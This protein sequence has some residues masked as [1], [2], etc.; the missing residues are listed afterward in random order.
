VADP[1]LEPDLDEVEDATAEQGPPGP[2]PPRP[3][4]QIAQ[5]DTLI[6]RPGYPGVYVRVLRGSPIPRDLAD[7]PRRPLADARKPRRARSRRRSPAAKRS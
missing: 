4:R 2:A 5:E 6:E 3:R 1:Y 7:A